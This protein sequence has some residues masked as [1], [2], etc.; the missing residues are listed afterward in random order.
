MCDILIVITAFIKWN[1]INL[2][3]Y[4]FY[5][6]FHPTVLCWMLFWSVL[7]KFH[8]EFDLLSLIVKCMNSSFYL[9]ITVQVTFH[10][11]RLWIPNLISMLL[12]VSYIV[13]CGFLNHFFLFFFRQ[14]NQYL[15]HRNKLLH[16]SNRKLFLSCLLQ[17]TANAPLIFIIVL[18]VNQSEERISHA[19]IKTVMIDLP[20]LKYR[21]LLSCVHN[22][23]VH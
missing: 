17:V 21:N 7:V 11:Y 5:N 4:F 9:T 2:Y 16:S 23:C 22:W 13:Y 10:Y 19:P 1:I 3:I 6:H 18:T 15:I 14:N 12:S 8:L 20:D